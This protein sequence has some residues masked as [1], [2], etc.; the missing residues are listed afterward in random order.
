MNASAL[1]AADLSSVTERLRHSTVKVREGRDGVGSGVVWKADGLIITNAHVARVRRLQ[2]EMSDGR[3]LPA[4]VEKRDTTRDLA[5]LR[6][7][8]DGLPV[9][10]VVRAAQLRVGDLVI[11]VGNPMGITGAAATGIVHAI[12]PAEGFEHQSWIQADIRLA[13]GNSGGPLA[14]VRGRV[15]GIN[16]MINRGLAMAV[17]S[18]SV[19][20]FLNGEDEQPRLGVTLKS[21]RMPPAC[22][23]L[24]IEELEQDG[25]AAR[26]GLQFGDVL[27]GCEGRPFRTHADLL[28]AL[29]E[30]PHGRPLRVNL[31]RAGREVAAE[32]LVRP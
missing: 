30:S 10:P 1:L 11:A 4:V 2:V 31:I 26:S 21:V 27:V 16:S 7:G 18:D 5:L 8:A 3:V 15:A 23:A 22:T 14:D 20:R 6:V 25:V 13:P 24:V 12:G 28:A 9:S 19:E 17:P 29:R 32:V